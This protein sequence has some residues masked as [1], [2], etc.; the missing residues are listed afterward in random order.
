MSST[1]P[2]A[3][4]LPDEEQP[5]RAELFSVERLEQH[6]ETLAAAQI[7]EADLTR[8]R[9]LTPRVLDNGRVLLESY[10]ALA[11]AIQQE[12]SITP[13]AEWLV[14]NFHI[15]DEQLR[16][17]REDLPPGFYRKLPKLAAGPLVG[18]PRVFGVA[19]AFVA[20]TDSRFDPEVLGRF[21][22]A[23]QRVQPLT[24]GELWAVAITLRVVLVE[25]LRRLA[26]GIVRSR[27]ARQEADTL[28]DSLLG[29]NGLPAL[30]PADLLKKF[31]GRNL[32]PAFGVQLLQRLRD[33]NPN[34]GPVL[35]W[36]DAQL[37]EEKTTAD[38]IVRQEHQQQAAMNVTVRNIIT[39]MRLM[40]AFEWPDFF[41]T[42]SLVDEILGK[43]TNFGELDFTTRDSYRH[44]IENL[45]RASRHTEVEIAQR[46]VQHV[47]RARIDVYSHSLPSQ[48][49]MTDPGYYLI[50]LGRPEFEREIGYR[51]S[52]RRRALR[53]YMET[54]LPGYLGTIALVTVAVMALPLLHDREAGVPGAALFFLGLLAIFPASDL[55]IALI[56]RMV[57]DWLGPRSLPRLDLRK[58]VPEHLRTIVVMPV[59]LTRRH[60]VEE[61]VSHL[62]IHYLANSE[63][64]LHFALLSDWADAATETLPTDDELLAAATE[65]I[66]ALNTR[67]G[68]APGGGERFL[69]FHRRRVWNEE[70]CKWMGWER[71]RG[72][73]HELNQFLRGA[74]NT[75]FVGVA[76]RAPDW[77]LATRYVIT[78]DADT[79]LPPGVTYR[80]VGTMAHPLN[81][82]EFSSQAERVVEGYG[83][84]QPRTMP[85]L[86]TGHGGS[87]FQEI[88]S[89]PSGMD[90]YA[91]AVSDVYHDLFREGSFTGK[92]IYEID[93]FQ[94]ALAGK[95]PENAL[96][97]HDLF[98]GIFARTGLVT[99]IELFEEFPMHYET[100]AARAHRWVRGD[101]QLLPW[102]FGRGPKG[103]AQRNP[104]KVPAVGRWKMIDNLR[105]SLSAPASFLLLFAGWLLP[106][107][108]PW[109]WTRFL[110]LTLAIPPLLPFLIGLDPRF[111]GVSKR[112]HLRALWGDLVI[113]LWQ[114][115]LAL[116]FL[117]YQAWLMS[118]A[119]A[120]TLA[121]LYV[122]H[123]NMLEW[124]TAAQAKYA[125]DFKLTNM[126]RR[127]AGGIAVAGAAG[128]ILALGRHSAFV[129]AA[130]FLAA[131]MLA[132]AVAQWI[133]IAPESKEAVQLSDSEEQILRVTARKTWRFFFTFVSAA[134]HALPPDNFQEDPK[135]V[136]AHRTSPTNIGLYLLSTLAAHD[137]G[138]IGTS[139]TVERLEE[140][141]ATM[142]R[143]ELFRGHFYNWYDTSDLRPLDPRYISSVDSGNLAGHLLALSRGCRELLE[144]PFGAGQLLAGLQ[145][146]ISILREPLT[147]ITDTKRTNIV[148]RKQLANAV[149][150]LA[151]SLQPLPEK[152]A[153]LAV[154]LTDLR[155]QIH[156]LADIA[157]AFAQQ[158][159]DA[160]ETELRAWTDATRDCMESHW[161]DAQILSPWTRLG[162]KEVAAIG[163]GG[164][165]APIEPLLQKIPRLS[166]AAT[167]FASVLIDLSALRER[168]VRDSPASLGVLRDI[169][170]FT[171]AVRKSAADAEALVNRLN[172]VAQTAEN[173]FHAMDFTFLFDSTRKLFSI[174]YR[175]SD[176]TIDAACY[177]LLASEARL[178]SFIAIAK[179]DA[180]STHWFRLGRTLT[181]VDRGSALISWSGSMF[182]YLMP[183]LV[184]HAPE[185]SVLSETARLV[186][187]RQIEYG[188][189][190]GV[191]WGVSESAF[192]ARDTDLRYQYSAFGVPG[193]GLKRGLSEDVVI[194]PYATAIAAMV[195]PVAAT[196]NITRLME[197]GAKGAYGLYE[198]LDYT[199]TRVPEGKKVA[200]IQ[201]YFAHHQGMTL[202]SLANVLTGG[203][204]QSRFHA[205]PIVKA[206]ELLLQEK[207]PRDVLVARPRAEEVSAARVRELV[208]PVL[209]RFL[210]P[211]E[212]SPRTQLLS[213]G[214]YAVMLT[215][216]GSGYSRWR[217]IAVTRWREDATRD[218]WGSYIY[219]RDSQ[220][221]QIWSAGH[222][223]AG[224]EAESYE[225]CF[226]EDR[227]EIQRRDRSVDTLLEVVVSS[228][229]DAELRR[230]S[231]TNHGL[232]TREIQV[233]S[234]SEICLTSQ[235]A[236]AAHPAFS[237]LFVETEFNAETGALLAT[238]RSQSGKDAPVWLAHV[239]AFEG[240]TVGSLEYETDRSQFIGRSRGTR[241]P[242][243]IFDATPLA[244]NTGPVLDPIVSLR[245]TMR[246]PPGT[247]ARV[248]F[249]TIIAST[250]EQALELADK[251]RDA[252]TF[253]RTLT[254][255]WTQAQ[256]QLRHL[257]VDP[258]EANLFQRLANAIL[259]ADAALRPSSDA[260]SRASLDLASL[261]SQGISG[262]R[263]IVL[264]FIDESDDIEIIR[265]LLRAH[266]YWRMK[267]LPVD[268]VIVNEKAHSYAQD[269][270]GALESL[271]RGNQLRV[272]PESGDALGN[273][274]LLK[275]DLLSPQLRAILQSVARAVLFGRR[276]T[277]SEQI[278]RSQRSGPALPPVP[279]EVSPARE[280]SASAPAPLVLED[281][282]FANGLGGFDENGREYVIVLGEGVRTP[283]PWINVIA[284]PSFGFIVSESGA[285]FTWSVNSHENQLTPWSN[286]PV[287]D[288][289]AEALYIRDQ[290]TGEI[291]SP[292]ALPVRDEASTYICR[293]GQGYSRFEHSSHGI[294][295]ELTQFV[296][297]KDP[298]KI[299]RLTLQNTSS[300]TRHLSIAAYAE[301]SLG[302]SRSAEAPYIVT[303]AD[304][305]TGAVFA[306]NSWEGEFAGR[307]AFADLGGKQASF[308]CD[309]KEF[310]GRNGTMALP[311]ALARD[312]RFS[313]KVGAG[314]DPCAALLASVELRP[315]GRAEI[316]FFLGQAENRVNAQEIILR[317]RAANLD[318]VLREVVASWEDVL[319]AVCVTTPEPALDVMLNR[320][321]LY[322]TLVCRVWGRAAFYQVSGAYGFRDQLQDV[323][324]L[325][326]AKREVAREHLLRAASRQFAE[327][328]V[329]HWW[330]PPS[331]RG[332]RTRIS[333]DL[334]W[335]P[336]AMS[337]FIEVTG[338]TAVLDE[339]VPFLEG[340]T[341]AEGQEVSYFQPRTSENKTT[342][343]EHCARAID[344]SLAVGAHGLPLMGTGDWN[345]GMNLVGEHGKGESV[346]LAWFMH[347]V[348]SEFAQ[349]ADSR[350]EGGRA[351]TWRLH[352]TALKAALE[353]EAW[354][355]DWYRRA[356]FDDGT[357]LGSAQNE[358]CK[359]DSI[360]QTW[361]V[362]SGAAEPGRAQRAMTAVDQNLVRRR[363]GLIL[364]LDP[365]FDHA[366]PSPGYIRGYVPGIRENGGQYTHAAAWTVFAFA[367]LG[368]GERAGEMFRMLNPINHTRSRADVQRY[369]VE[370]YV[371][372]GDIYSEP[373][374]V[375][376]GG[377][378]WYSGSAGWLYRVG[379]ESILGFRLRGMSLSID[380]C[381]PRN[382]SNFS[383]SFRYHSTTYK[384]KVENPSSVMRGIALTRVD[385]KMLPGKATISLVDDGAEHEI[386]V[387]M[388]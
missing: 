123:R 115:G 245:R 167:Y 298:V 2:I 9:P 349:I 216:A 135:P 295:H 17:I 108:S 128:L 286:D 352:V 224:V 139:E 46:V 299:S 259:Y 343:F 275:A 130:P 202:V 374:H 133:S 359:I 311:A 342:L 331:G 375:A 300:R 154:R 260:L 329:Q 68:P 112:S 35:E 172:A 102:I 200:V 313:G 367:A 145:D 290:A 366:A 50:S 119:I 33:V 282:A 315:G 175:V 340:D 353:R 158:R 186:V 338:D 197:A 100:A 267:N 324:A 152:S 165:W 93:A 233:T 250:R 134:D 382:W 71:K 246:I 270:H 285:G 239:T 7:V 63:G 376:R 213:N 373:P 203:L 91:T 354:D 312:D 341:L 372:A 198:A 371:V 5:I 41:E 163:K 56:N 278:N 27:A 124:V 271:V 223:P 357:P 54:A 73:L 241:N 82:P 11:Q 296:P 12:H 188:T 262:D 293:H 49:P 28:A 218:C 117:A 182:E 210:T 242:V 253:E 29:T 6:A 350:G 58:G 318:D 47:K 291:W 101:W 118:D 170:G 248:I 59:L 67:Y 204:M 316:V 207:T 377:W 146:C 14:D 62:E 361:G 209:R 263:P 232:R 116:T 292:T 191:P 249:S 303:E 252:T 330:H 306:R 65:G 281:L 211:H 32:S 193:L 301:W 44:A 144:K 370:P 332:V 226:F 94:A 98:E 231:I 78:L 60:E 206:V 364:L 240:E 171:D 228:D 147:A 57:T 132:P 227:A 79:R 348:L 53:S 179:G 309:R 80:L 277:L 386:L 74:T 166:D 247:T 189:E 70:E 83:I 192:N 387:V 106:P 356:Y 235:A 92:G 289:P 220:T 347:L 86:P 195:D 64:N 234:Y 178:T 149:E 287:S 120:R 48:E 319:G 174:G 236:D 351:E 196:Q 75:T 333:D 337:R 268:V 10:R 25:N 20:H 212:A 219:L 339:P 121:R 205:A 254:L 111:G 168:V 322:Q 265:Q 153:A 185:D 321:L 284:N 51:L 190:R 307:I 214:R 194:A 31:E 76:E 8:G 19:W 269:L 385:G 160:V 225:A 137:L 308:T 297:L 89:G 151:G 362:I 114:A 177:D 24:I 363:D 335:L 380:P 143:L 180:E 23:Y 161:R 328:D 283:Q 22:K 181:P 140:T 26:E 272:S 360:A 127:M 3:T 208:P 122:T 258:D 72:K 55:A 378:T 326:I 274:Y 104:V 230:V 88:F 129:A 256:V 107:A 288:P 142:S 388:G 294:R 113:G 40:S 96:L 97:S 45:S 173:M 310:I 222:Q 229:D 85:T 221:G 237:N 141:L 279:A 1:T 344:R 336:Y 266:E 317:Y 37:A 164:D 38:D 314:L 264:A 21:V 346:W 87:L 90:A 42:V 273:I 159:S 201:A 110:I 383:I 13:A 99:D 16:E 18:Y 261:W 30:P 345:D 126:Y 131:W 95:V 109:V 183:V 39:S 138:C 136:V 325:C 369:K 365:P 255:A 280:R 15:V 148:T 52:W 215:S 217:D 157:H 155:T 156:T 257:G 125:V 84:M 276:G 43:D 381:V 176:G 36:L 305:K 368:D 81:R 69:L 334:L 251:H 61:L 323:L 304:S 355:G 184:M 187:R 327:G 199:A 244:K 105:R 103:I 384:I 379:L 169:D 320:W 150:A 34:V 243:S 238:R 358:E 66:A 77:L 162:T 4:S 302:S